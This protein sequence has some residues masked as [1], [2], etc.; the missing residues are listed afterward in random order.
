MRIL[1]LRLGQSSIPLSMSVYDIDRSIG[2]DHLLAAKVTTSKV[3]PTTAEIVP[4]STVVVVGDIVI[5]HSLAKGQYL[6]SVSVL[7]SQS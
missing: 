6:Q 4:I 1:S 3:I 7:S 2:C 5:A